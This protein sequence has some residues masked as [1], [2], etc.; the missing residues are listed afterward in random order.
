VGGTPA[1]TVTVTNGVVP[2]SDTV[3]FPNAGTFFWAGRTD[4]ARF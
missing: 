4:R 3:T 1:G 2:D